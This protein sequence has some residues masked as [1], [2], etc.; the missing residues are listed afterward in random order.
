MKEWH[1]EG[2]MTDVTINCDGKLIH[3]NMLVLASIPYLWVSPLYN[4]SNDVRPMSLECCI[5]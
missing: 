2:K 4:E 1:R 5:M 3:A